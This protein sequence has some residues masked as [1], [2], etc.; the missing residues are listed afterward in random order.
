MNSK[1][2]ETTY[3]CH[4]LLTDH[5]FVRFDVLG[6]FGDPDAAALAA[7]LWLQYVCLVLLLPRV[8]LQVAVAAIIQAKYCDHI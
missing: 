8:R 1:I 6:V 2:L 5:M 3:P 4:V 7:R